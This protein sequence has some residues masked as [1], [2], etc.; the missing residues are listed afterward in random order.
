MLSTV[1][2][3]VARRRNPCRRGHTWTTRA[4]PPACCVCGRTRPAQLAA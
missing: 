1:I 2:E 3:R 4:N